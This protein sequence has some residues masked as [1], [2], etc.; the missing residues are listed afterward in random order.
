MRELRFLFFVLV[1]PVWVYAQTVPFP[2]DLKLSEAFIL[3]LKKDT[4][5]K[6]IDVLDSIRSEVATMTLL[7]RTDWNFLNGIAN[8]QLKR[9]EQA[10]PFLSTA[11]ETAS[12]S[13]KTII[14][15][16]IGRAYYMKRN[17]AGAE[18]SLKKAQSLYIK[19]N[20]R[21][22]SYVSTLNT[23]AIVSREQCKYLEAKR[24]FKEAVLTNESLTGGKGKQYGRVTNG[25]AEIHG[26]I[27]EYSDAIRYFNI[28][29]KTKSKG[30][31]DYAKTL[32]KLADFQ[33][34]LGSHETADGLIRE[35][36][37]ICQQKKDSSP[38]FYACLDF[39]CVLTVRMGNSEAAEVSFEDALQRRKSQRMEGTAEYALN[40]LNLCGLYMENSHWDKAEKLINET[41]LSIEK[42]YTKQH[43]R[44]AAAQLI[45]ARIRARNKKYQ[46]AEN[47][48]RSASDIME[49]K[50]G[51]DHIEY[52]NAKLEYA[53]FLRN[54]SRKDEAI[55][56]FK[57]IDQIPKKILRK[58]SGYISEKEL[59]DQ[60]KIFKNY[61]DEIY[62]LLWLWPDNS[63]LIEIAYNSQLFYKGYI[64]K[65]VQQIRRKVAQ[66]GGLRQSFLELGALVRTRQEE[67]LKPDSLQEQVN[68]L[69][70][71]IRQ[72][73]LVVKSYAGFQEEDSGETSWTDVKN[74][75]PSRSAVVEY[76]AFKNAERGDSVFYGAI[77]LRS[78]MDYPQ[79]VSLGS[80]D[81]IMSVLPPDVY[82]TGLNLNSELRSVV[83]SSRKNTSLYKL[84]WEPLTISSLEVSTIYIV[85]D[86]IL[87]RI[88]FYA[89]ASPE[90]EI[91]YL[92]KEYDLYI[93]GSSR[94]IPDA[95][96]TNLISYKNAQV[97][98]VGGLDY[99]SGAGD[100]TSR[101]GNI[102]GHIY[103]KLQFTDSEV[104]K[105]KQIL[106]KQGMI[107]SV[108]KQSNARKE[109]ILDTLQRNT[110][111]WK[112]LHFATHGYYN[113]DTINNS[114]YFGSGM[115]NSGIILSGINECQGHDCELLAVEISNLDLNGVDLV[116][117]SSCESAL[118]NIEDQEGLFG[119]SRA[120]RMAGVRTQLASIRKIN[121]KPTEFFMQQFY[122]SLVESSFNSH[123]AFQKALK[124]I[125][126]QP[127]AV[128]DSWAYFVLLE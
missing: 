97:L 126:A 25:L 84:I 64:L 119:L 87:H 79:F 59:D 4:P 36:L 69:E 98:L 108:F 118:G 95:S 113:P 78:E 93:L 17:L 120:F 46:E 29:L 101:S 73:E 54:M 37:S 20:K 62:S 12:D 92:M 50:L 121:D 128:L 43:P 86:G 102:N 112:M 67:L 123:V 47:L 33:S 60:V 49:K 56:I 38:F 21:D 22:S 63:D 44:F 114:G 127:T 32:Y 90:N 109:V 74:Q 6:G 52:F 14:L 35:C 55:A 51:R 40:L 27:G 125:E 105:I 122:K 107:V 53:R 39:Q 13:A 116:V 83:K 89:L 31:L 75:L 7:Q 91:N 61:A 16:A 85:P 110:G 9:Y 81:I 42:I 82:T 80:Y 76:M 103:D 23:L 11:A 124:I 48:F 28:S 72:M 58:S 65:Q 19:L 94:K 5:Q 70:S 2:V 99:G 88:S 104:D 68:E 115:T 18:E 26:L 1:S 10:I 30:S 100:I 106:S 57:K 45:Q 24:I 3:I 41:L 71:K 111:K 66:S 77:V 96:E 8:Y 34:G 15:D 117:L